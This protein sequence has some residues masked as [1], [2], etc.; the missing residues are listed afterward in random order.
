MPTRA[1]YKGITSER[2]ERKYTIYK[3]R[4]NSNNIK[5]RSCYLEVIRIQFKYKFRSVKVMPNI[6]VMMIIIKSTY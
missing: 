4:Q 2:K 1:N 5:D 6:K 3:T